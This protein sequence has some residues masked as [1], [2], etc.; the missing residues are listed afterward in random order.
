MNP[1]WSR[2]RGGPA[3]W[4][5]DYLLGE[6]ATQEIGRRR[7]R[8]VRGPAPALLRGDPRI[9]VR[10]IDAPETTRRYRCATI[11]FAKTEVDIGKWRR[12]DPE[13]LRK[14]D[15]AVA[16][17]VEAAHSG[18]AAEARPPILVGTHLHTG[19][20]ETNVLVLACVT[21][22]TALGRRVPRA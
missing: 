5:I 6:T 14:I 13:T 10:T 3:R 20:L 11:S 21:I 19:R 1:V 9:V 18:I 4:V 16:L 8:C 2:H 22:A 17:W 7:A 15:A 12:R